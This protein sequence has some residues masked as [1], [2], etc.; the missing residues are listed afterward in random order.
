[1][2]DIEDIDK[3]IN[4]NIS[5]IFNCPKEQFNSFIENQNKELINLLTLCR[6]ELKTYKFR[7]DFLEK[8]NINTI[9]E[10]QS[11]ITRQ[12]ILIDTYEKHCKMQA[13]TIHQYKQQTDTILITLDQY[14]RGDRR[15]ETAEGR[16]PLTRNVMK[17]PHAECNEA[18]SRGRFEPTRGL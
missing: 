9:N 16:P 15:G 5:C 17:H 12:Q 18:P 11:Q 4:K 2:D 13:E 7:H 14:K 8:S 3:F 1:M 6:N 10:F